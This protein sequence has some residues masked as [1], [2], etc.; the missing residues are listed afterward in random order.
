M[1]LNL[2]KKC[3]G[4]KKRQ[5]YIQVFWSF[6]TQRKYTFLPFVSFKYDACFFFSSTSNPREESPLSNFYAARFNVSGKWYTS[7]EQFYM[8]KKAGKCFSSYLLTYGLYF[9]V[10]W[11]PRYNLVV[12]MRRK[13]TNNQAINTC[14]EPERYRLTRIKIYPIAKSGGSRTL[15][16]GVG[17]MGWKW[18]L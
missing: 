17:C 13:A 2:E 16:S 11:S 14:H 3:R 4:D 10:T 5:A 15:M 8:Y 1:W 9:S 6:K 12:V 7:T 18:G